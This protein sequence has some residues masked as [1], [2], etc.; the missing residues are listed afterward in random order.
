MDVPRE[1]YVRCRKWGKNRGRDHSRSRIHC[2]V[3]TRL[4][5]IVSDRA[6]IV[7]RSSRSGADLGDT[8]TIPNQAATLR[9][10][11]RCH[12]DDQHAERQQSATSRIEVRGDAVP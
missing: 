4:R 10:E 2:R 9:Q 11:S 6:G 3:R 5:S 8:M 1:Q 7:T 12:E